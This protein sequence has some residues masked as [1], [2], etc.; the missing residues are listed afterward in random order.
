MAQ[1]GKWFLSL[2]SC[3][4]STTGA[5]YS[6][7]AACTPVVLGI[8]GSFVP[9]AEGL[10]F[11]GVGLGALRWL[12]QWRD[13]LPLLRSVMSGAN[14]LRVHGLVAGAGALLAAVA[15]SYAPAAVQAGGMALHSG[16]CR[17]F[18]SSCFPHFPNDGRS[19]IGVQSMGRVP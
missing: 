9:E 5:L 6:C 1:F 19:N 14:S 16:I 12:A 7:V 11:M 8:L 4:P 18:I 3:L 2:L 15:L 10:G 13:Y 17:K